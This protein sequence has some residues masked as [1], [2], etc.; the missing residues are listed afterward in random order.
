MFYL[1]WQ[2]RFSETLPEGTRIERL[3]FS[4]LDGK[5]FT[6]DEINMPILLV[7][8][9]TKS[10]LTSNIYPNLFLRT[11]PELAKLEELGYLHI[12]IL[13]DMEQNEE[14]V[15]KLLLKK[16]YKIL[17][18]RIF[19]GNTKRMSEY[20]GVGSWPHSFLLDKDK[21]IIHQDKVPSAERILGI[22]KGV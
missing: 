9:N 15:K 18:N 22:L 21:T 17:E 10:F 5:S 12:I 11:M 3:E 8:F 1:L 14:N 6:T 13:T 20:F 16:K 4:T 19:L 7:F 2:S